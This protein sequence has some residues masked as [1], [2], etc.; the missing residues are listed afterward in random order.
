[1][2]KICM[3][4]TSELQG[5]PRVQREAQF[6]HDAGHDVTVVCREYQGAALPYTVLPLNIP[7]QKQK[8]GKYLERLR[9]NLQLILTVLRLR[10]SLVHANDFDTLP[11]GYIGSRLV[12]A[13]LV[14][15]S[16]ELWNEVACCSTS[17][18]FSRAAPTP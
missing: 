1:M 4:V 13:K 12:G 2:A 14:Y 17:S 5:D 8:L 18:A 16:H 3:L 15:D 6:T 10:P 7:R 11:A 9:F